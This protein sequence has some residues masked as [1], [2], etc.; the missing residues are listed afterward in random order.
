MCLGPGGPRVDEVVE[1]VAGWWEG[2]DIFLIGGVPGEVPHRALAQLAVAQ[3]WLSKAKVHRN[4]MGELQLFTNL[5]GEVRRLWGTKR[6]YLWLGWNVVEHAALVICLVFLLAA[7]AGGW[8]RT[9]F[10]L[11]PFLPLFL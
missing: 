3:L 1:H 6:T 10:S 4:L 9:T 11:D 8:C 5:A 7:H 2:V